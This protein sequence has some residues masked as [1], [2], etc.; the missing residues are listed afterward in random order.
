[1][2]DEIKKEVLGK[3]VT[4]EV[5]PDI[6]LLAKVN[7]DGHMTWKIPA[8]LQMAMYLNEHLRILIADQHLTRIAQSMVKEKAKKPDIITSLKN[9]IG[10]LK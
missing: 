8:N 7:K 3:S 4:Q 5:K 10:I 2:A 9:S 1:M 6:E